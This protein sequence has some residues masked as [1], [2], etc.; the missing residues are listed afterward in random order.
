[1][2]FTKE[3]R[4]RHYDRYHKSLQ[5]ELK[6]EHDPKECT[7]CGRTFKPLNKFQRFCRK[8]RAKAD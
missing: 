6:T 4:K 3:Q 2:M 7:I 1:M 8:C 5:S